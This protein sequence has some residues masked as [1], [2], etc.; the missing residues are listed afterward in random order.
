MNVTTTTS[1][2]GTLGRVYGGDCNLVHIK[3]GMR[4]EVGAQLAD[5]L[6][7]QIRLKAMAQGKLNAADFDSK[8]L[9]PGC[10]MIALFNVAIHLADANGQSRTELG[11]TMAQAF[12]KLADNPAE[13]LTEEIEVILDN[14]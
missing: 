10:F 5:A 7:T 9:C 4:M 8:P 2:D 12:A 3:D 11:R 1:Q 14:D 13:G 6:D